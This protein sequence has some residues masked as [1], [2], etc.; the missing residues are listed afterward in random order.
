M[1]K[2]LAMAAVP[3]TL[4]PV[5]RLLAALILAGLFAGAPVAVAQEAP[6]V[7][8]ETT[9]PAVR[10]FLDLLADPAVRDWLARQ[11]VAGRTATTPGPTAA[12]PS[13]AAAS[14]SHDLTMRLEAIRHHVAALAAALPALPDEFRRAGAT[15]YLGVPT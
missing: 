2:Q 8:A 10:Q 4:H 11:S 12:D 15:L 1:T 5:A 9:Q 7:A 13:G 3:A 6:P 14:P